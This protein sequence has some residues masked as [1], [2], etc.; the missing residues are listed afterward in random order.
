MGIKF[1]EKIMLY[2]FREVKCEQGFT[3]WIWYY[4]YDVLCL[5]IW[6][7]IIVLM[8][9]KSGISCS[10]SGSFPWDRRLWIFPSGG[11]EFSLQF[12]IRVLTKKQWV[13]N[14]RKRFYGKMWWNVLR[15]GAAYENHMRF[16][17]YDGPMVM[18]VNIWCIL[19]WIVGL[20]EINFLGI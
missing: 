2:C 11:Y 14:K 16:S 18:S 12:F 20:A 15:G 6:T 13:G 5:T 10:S 17:M 1:K 8:D 7:Y 9:S 4:Q 19:D 3:P